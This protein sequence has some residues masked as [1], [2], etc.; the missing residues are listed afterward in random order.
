MIRNKTTGRRI[1][2]IALAT[3]ILSATAFAAV[4]PGITSQ[5]WS[6]A[7]ESRTPQPDAGWSNNY[8]IPSVW[9]GDRAQWNN[10]A[11][12]LGTDEMDI[13]IPNYQV[14]Q[15]KKEMQIELVWRAAGQNFLPDRPLIGVLPLYDDEGINYSEQ[16]MLLEEGAAQ[17]TTPLIRTVFAVDIW[18][19]PSSEW[20][21]IKGDIDVFSVA[22]DTRCIPEPAT[23]GLLI[24]GALM[25]I[26]RKRKV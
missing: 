9:I 20:I 6:F 10:G 21:T 1:L 24:G 3:M 16:I 5:Q 8:G 13:I 4:D 22:V 25:A 11:W 12:T 15:P 17:A 2:A 18:P 14:L 7:T 23:L 26:R 19:N